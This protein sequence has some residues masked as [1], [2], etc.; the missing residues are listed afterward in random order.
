MF[1]PKTN[2]FPYPKDTDRHYLKVR[3]DR[4]IVFDADYPYIDRSKRFRFL[5]G[6]VRCG[7]YAL[8]FPLCRL[9]LGLK[10]EG[11]SNLKKHRDTLKNGVISVSNHVHM[12]DYIALMCAIRPYRPN[13]LSWAP[14]INGENGTLI[15]LTGGIPIPETGMAATRAQMSAVRR[16]LRDDHGWLQI[17]SEGSMWEFYAPIRPFKRGASFLACDS[18]KPVL[19]LGFSF[20]EPSWLRKRVF[21][22]IATVTLRIGEP[23]FPRGELTGKD[24]EQD[25]TVRT[26][27]AVC[28]LA[29]IDPAENLYPPLFD[30]AKRVDYYT[31]TYGVGYRGSH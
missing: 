9:R 27:D 2:K 25:L 12:W 22:Q 6:A 15:R 18:D 26:H 20:R 10:I 21:R 4:G 29:G 7:L 13:V 24:R 5:Q 8:V 3:K 17:Y 28:R 19:P 11:R 31:T 23:L 30:N 1:D 16:L 14:D